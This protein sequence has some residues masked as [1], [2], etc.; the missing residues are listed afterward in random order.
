MPPC[1]SSRI[2]V[3]ARGLAARRSGNRRRPERVHAC[4][5]PWRDAANAVPGRPWSER[6]RPCAPPARRASSSLPPSLP[7]PAG[8][9]APRAGAR[10]V[11]RHCV[12]A[13]CIP[14]GAPDRRPDGVAP[15]PAPAGPRTEEARTCLA[16]SP[17]P[18]CRPA[19]SPRPRR[20]GWKRLVHPARVRP[21]SSASTGRD[22]AI[23]WRGP[24]RRHA[25][26]WA[27]R[28]NSHLSPAIHL[29]DRERRGRRAAMAA[30]AGSRQEHGST[31]VRDGCS[32][33]LHQRLI[34]PWPR[35]LSSTAE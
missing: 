34:E 21:A 28:S 3:P 22:A 31:M 15:G 2:P 10:A 30:R 23:A 4:Q 29:P 1:L 19:C 11:R 18:A 16:P 17:R 8:R 9:L 13:P 33:E 24:R 32:T 25:H 5:R 14:L 6:Q 7:S 26:P 12:R 27:E 20:P 35:S